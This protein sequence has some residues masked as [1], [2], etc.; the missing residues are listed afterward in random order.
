[1]PADKNS[2]SRSRDSFRISNGPI[3]RAPKSTDRPF[4]LPDFV[5]LPTL[6]GEPLLFAIARDPRTIFAYWNIDWAAIFEK[7]APV[8]RQAHLRV[9]RD[10]IQES[11]VPVEP[12]TG[13]HYL[14]VSQPREKYLVEIGYYQPKSVWHSVATSDSVNMPAEGAAENVDVDLATIPFH[15]SFQRLIDL[16]RAQNGDALAEIIARLQRS[17][18]SSDERDLLSAEEWEILRAMDLSLDQLDANQ[19][20]LR[21]GAASE[22]LRKHAEGILGFGATSP[23]RG[24]G[25]SSWS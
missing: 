7:S 19:R 24:F 13:N 2:N 22:Q 4:D 23:S 1:M 18:V 14:K 6:S 12:M 10:N 25:E 9:H 3:A 21:N 11:S 15:L 20:V 17:A 16:F 8:D 5:Q